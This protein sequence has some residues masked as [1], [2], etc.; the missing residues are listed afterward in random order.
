M[1]DR[2][3]SGISLDFSNTSFKEKN[4]IHTAKVKYYGIGRSPR[5]ATLLFMFV[6]DNRE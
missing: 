1:D 6:K 4:D 3:I 2:V 5:E